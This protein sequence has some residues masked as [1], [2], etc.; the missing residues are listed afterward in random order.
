MATRDTTLSADTLQGSLPQNYNVG[1]KITVGASDIKLTKVTKLAGGTENVA[2]I[3]EDDRSTVLDT[4]S[5]SSNEATFD[6]TLTASTTYYIMVS[7]NSGTYSAQRD[8]SQ[9][10]PVD[11]TEV[12]MIAGAQTSEDDSSRGWAIDSLDLETSTDAGFSGSALALSL[13]QPSQDVIVEVPVLA[14]GS[15]LNVREPDVIRVSKQRSNVATG[16]VGSAMYKTN[17]HFSGS[18]FVKGRRYDNIRN[19]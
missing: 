12:S 6:Y 18:K 11:M 19:L 5:F 15:A 14:V 3:L 17:Y 9:T 7:N 1:I 13:G 2:K 16:S 10:Y 4:Q 8:D